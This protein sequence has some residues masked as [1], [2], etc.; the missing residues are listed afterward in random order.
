MYGHLVG[1]LPGALLEV[2]QEGLVQDLA[3]VIR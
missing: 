3:V 1:Q 2:E